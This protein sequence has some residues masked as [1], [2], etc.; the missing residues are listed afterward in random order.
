MLPAGPYDV[1]VLVRY[2][3][4][5]LLRHLLERLAPGGVLLCEQHSQTAEDV[6][7]PRSPAFRMSAN[8]LLHAVL[9]A[10]GP[11]HRVRYYRDG[12]V[13]DPDARHAALAQLVLE[14]R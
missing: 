13:T 6:V 8:A 11:A 2:V 3:N 5:P 10:S 1:I 12:V 14:R 7:G 4:T 9:D